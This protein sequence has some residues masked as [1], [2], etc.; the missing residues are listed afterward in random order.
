MFLPNV[1]SKKF[2]LLPFCCEEMTATNGVVHVVAV[3]D[4]R[5]RAL[6]FLGLDEELSANG[7]DVGEF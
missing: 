1:C 7:F 2:F 5:R 4:S 3:D 6:Q